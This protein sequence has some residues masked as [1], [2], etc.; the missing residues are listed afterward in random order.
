M[1]NA[2]LV[3]TVPHLFS[4]LSA[5]KAEIKSYIYTLRFNVHEIHFTKH[6]ILCIEG[7]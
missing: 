6:N 2:R 5:F 7:L 4:S 3:I 1:R